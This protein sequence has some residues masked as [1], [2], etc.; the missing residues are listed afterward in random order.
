M[1]RRGWGLCLA[2]LLGGCVT[3]NE[4][5]VDPDAVAPE[6]VPTGTPRRFAFAGLDG[7]PVTHDTLRGRM[8]LIVFTATYDTASQAQARFVESVFH[9]H[10][11]RINALLLVL[12]PPHHRPLVEAFASA[13]DLSYPVAIA[14]A[15]TIA[16][17][18]PFSGL[19]HVPALVLLDRDGREVW[20]HVGLVEKDALHQAIE[21][22]DR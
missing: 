17:E 9:E 18:G 14:D 15:K 6:E 10:A 16:G 21:K 1:S 11:P 7:A 8:S 20:R 5:I 12:E 2:A 4:P 22:H 13:L 3:S 19:H